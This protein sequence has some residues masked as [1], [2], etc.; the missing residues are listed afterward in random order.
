[1]AFSK[2]FPK[3]SDKSIYPVWEDIFLTKEEERAV[4]DD[5]REE[6]VLL[7]QECI[8]DAKVIMENKGLK[9][10]QSDLIHLAI[11]LFEKRASHS[12]YWKE[13]AAKE[14]FDLKENNQ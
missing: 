6:N 11:A 4:E 10:F 7:M 9:D 13:N 2:A 3:R 12:V 1:M 8:A 5:C 14:K